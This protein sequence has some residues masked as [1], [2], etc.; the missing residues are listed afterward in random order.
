VHN[1]CIKQN[2]VVDKR[3]RKAAAAVEF[4]ADILEN[5]KQNMIT[6]EILTFTLLV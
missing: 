2:H 3:I 4:G 5:I 6:L 1:F